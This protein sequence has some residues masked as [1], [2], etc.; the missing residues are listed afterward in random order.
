MKKFIVAFGFAAILA[1]ASTASAQESVLVDSAPAAVSSVAVEA[2]PVWSGRYVQPGRQVRSSQRR[3]VF[4]GLIE[5]E[6]RKNAWLKRTFLG[7]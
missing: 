6:R 3:G 1:A 5:L 2:A 4:S 7:R